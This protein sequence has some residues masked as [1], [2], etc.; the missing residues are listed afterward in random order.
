MSDET[1]ID[2]GAPDDGADRRD[3]RITA[4]LAVEPLDDV[5]RRRLV[6]G[7]LEAQPKRP[8]VA[9]A[10]SIAAAIAI[11]AV[12]GAVLVHRN[13]PTTQTAAPASSSPAINGAKNAA[14]SDAVAAQPQAGFAD[15]ATPVT[16]LGDLGDVSTA[17]GLRSALDAAF[18]RAG[19]PQEGAAAAYPCASI[20]PRSVGLVA[21]S[22]V[23]TGTRD[24][25]AVTVFVGTAP[26]GRTLAVV[27][28]VSGC[29]SV[30]T[31][32]FT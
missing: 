30:T 27:L 24:G 20:Q 32:T 14:P 31:I 5:T 26:D 8:R 16:P 23:G 10:M 28:R 25:N 18:D 21:I 22:A 17:K 6:R 7:A 19:G 2:T 12:I 3:E 29:A 11:G 15:S 13:A 9:A 4:L 1:T